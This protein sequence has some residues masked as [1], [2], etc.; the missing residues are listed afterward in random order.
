VIVVDTSVW[1]DY[2]NGIDSRQTV[3]LDDLLAERPL[4]MGDLIL[5]ELLH[6]DRDLTVME[7]HLGLRVL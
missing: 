4:L 1:I 5:V 3:L 6:A 7:Q 2:F